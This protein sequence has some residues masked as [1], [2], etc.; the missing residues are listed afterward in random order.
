[1]I[2]IRGLVENALVKITDISGR[3]VFQTRALG[4]QAVWNGVD[5]TGHRPQSGVYLVFAAGATGGEHLVTKI[6][7]VN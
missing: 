1:M 7:F 5:Y 4:G 6:L 3:M 2:A